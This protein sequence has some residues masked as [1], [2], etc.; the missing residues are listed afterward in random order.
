M[1][2]LSGRAWVSRMVPRTPLR[3]LVWVLALGLLAGL[4]YVGWLW[5]HPD[6]FPDAG[7]STKGYSAAKPGRAAWFGMGY[8]DEDAGGTITIRDVQAHGVEDTADAEIEFFVCTIDRSA[9]IGGIGVAGPR[10]IEDSCSS[11]VPA[12]GATIHLDADLPEQIV[13][14]VTLGHPGGCGSRAWT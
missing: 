10:D 8:E 9:R 1:T 14:S 5:R 6:V 11:L 4:G 13:A 12:E 3:L 2:H 7:S